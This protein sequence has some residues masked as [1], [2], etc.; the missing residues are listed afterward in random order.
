MKLSIVAAMS[1]NRVIGRGPEIPWRV[2]DDQKAV[3]ELTRGHCLVMGR[4]TWDTIRRPLPGRTS[5]VLT[6]DLRFDPGHP[7]VLVAHDFDAALAMAHARGDDEVFAFGGE[8]I[9]ALAL[10]RADTLHLT[11][12]HVEVEGDAF[13]P[14]FDANEWELESESYHEADERNEH[15][16]TTRIYRRKPRDS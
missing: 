16:F 1:E 13:F 11:T 3:R 15:A 9:Y 4:K 8:A 7:D 5:I 6:R 14:D 12:V 10:G 2:R